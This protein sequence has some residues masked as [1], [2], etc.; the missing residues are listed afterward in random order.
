M[1]EPTKEEIRKFLKI[2]DLLTQFEAEQRSIRGYGAIKEEDC[3]VPSVVR[4]YGWLKEKGRSY[5]IN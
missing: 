3:L 2:F 1:T 5:E 4:V